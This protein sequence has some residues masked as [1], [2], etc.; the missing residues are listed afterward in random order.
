MASKFLAK[1]ELDAWECGSDECIERHKRRQSRCCSGRLVDKNDDHWLRTF[2]VL[3]FRLPD[4]V[5]PSSSTFARHGAYVREL[6]TIIIFLMF[7]GTDLHGGTAPMTPQAFVGRIE[8]EIAQK[9][10]DPQSVNRVM[11]VGFPQREHNQ[12]TAASAVTAPVAFG[13]RAPMSSTE[14]PPQNY[15]EDGRHLLGNQADFMNRMRREIVNQAHDM[16]MLAGFHDFDPNHFLSALRY[17]PVEDPSSTRSCDPL[18]KFNPHTAQ[19][20]C[21]IE[22]GQRRL[23]VLA[24]LS[25]LLYLGLGLTKEGYKLHG[26]K[27]VDKSAPTDDMLPPIHIRPVTL[28]RA[29]SPQVADSR[30]AP[31]ND[32]QSASAAIRLP[33]SPRPVLSRRAICALRISTSGTRM[34]AVTI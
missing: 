15:A 17:T 34:V 23:T 19:G 1:A 21:E 22:Y 30:S 9:F 20:R 29:T 6:N 31:T 26:R 2:C 11:L 28:R 12:R 14:N 24:H 4:G 5:D 16:A 32:D 7:K 25:N 33:V 18:V 8:D 27:R 3:C 13:N 10:S